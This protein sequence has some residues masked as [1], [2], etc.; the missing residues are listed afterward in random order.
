MKF[1]YFIIIF[2]Q[3]NK[4][5][6]FMP[7]SI[8]N[9]NENSIL[10]VTTNNIFQQKDI[11]EYHEDLINDSIKFCKINDIGTNPLELKDTICYECDFTMHKLNLSKIYKLDDKNYCKFCC[12]HNNENL[13]K[14]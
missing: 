7:K 3:K 14:L 4:Y 6:F 11:D 9:N 10:N 2:Y 8:L 5:Q 13:F 1:K 12:D